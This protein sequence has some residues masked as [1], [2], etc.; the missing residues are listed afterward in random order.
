MACPACE[1]PPPRMVRGQRKRLQIS[2]MRIMSPGLR[3]CDSDGLDLIDAGVGG[4]KRSGYG[5]EADL[6]GDVA[7]EFGQRDGSTTS[8]T[9]ED[10]QQSIQ[11]ARQSV[12]AAGKGDSQGAFAAGSVS[13]AVHNHHARIAH[14]ALADFVRGHS[15]R[16][17]RPAIR[18]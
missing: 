8:D 2:T 9:P 4:I 18:N 13:R 12:A 11:S 15:I 14:Q 7:L 5:V 10:L 1:V 3:D 16:E 17:R 6:A